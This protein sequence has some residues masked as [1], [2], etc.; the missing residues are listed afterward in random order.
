MTNSKN[1]IEGL[2]VTSGPAEMM[3]NQMPGPGPGLTFS[4][5]TLVS[6]VNYSIVM[7]IGEI[8]EHGKSVDEALGST[9]KEDLSFI[10]KRIKRN[11]KGNKI[12]KINSRHFKVLESNAEVVDQ[13]NEFTLGRKSKKEYLNFIKEVNQKPKLLKT[14]W[15]I[16]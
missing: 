13:I 2:R 7:F 6:F 11:A 8:F 9:N 14:L 16:K 1:I 12:E 4:L 15:K 10:V 5:E 3:H